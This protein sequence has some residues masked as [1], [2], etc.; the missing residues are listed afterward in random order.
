MCRL[1]SWILL[2]ISPCSTQSGFTGKAY[3]ST[4]NDPGVLA[5]MKTAPNL[6]ESLGLV[7]CLSALSSN[8][9]AHRNTSPIRVQHDDAARVAIDLFCLRSKFFGGASDDL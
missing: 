1:G 2:Q 9:K 5:C 3:F 8:Q 7:L 4:V 6:S